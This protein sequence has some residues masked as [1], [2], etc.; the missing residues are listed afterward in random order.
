MESGLTMLLHSVVTMVYILG[1]RQAVYPYRGD[2]ILFGHG[3]SI[4]PGV[5]KLKCLFFIQPD[6]YCYNGYN[7]YERKH[8]Y[9]SG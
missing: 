4:R 2:M 3:P 6:A 1:Q 5:R 7:D 9:K 8:E